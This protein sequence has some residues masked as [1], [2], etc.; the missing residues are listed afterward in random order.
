MRLI[1][2]YNGLV[3]KT[4]TSQEKF[5][6][7]FN[8]G[9]INNF[10][11]VCQD[12]DELF[13][14]CLPASKWLVN[15]DPLKDLKNM[16]SIVETIAPYQFSKV[17]LISTIDVYNGM[18]QGS[19]EDSTIEPTILTYGSN[20]YLFEQMVQTL[21]KTTDLRIFRLPAL[22]SKDIK[23]NVLY[24][25]LNSNMVENI[26]IASKYQW[27]NLEY[28]SRDIAKYS[29]EYPQR[30]TYNLFSEPLETIEIV[31][32]FPQYSLDTFSTKQEVEYDYRTVLSQD[33]YI[34]TK[35]SVLQD[36]RA[37]V[38]EVSSK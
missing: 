5:D 22:F 24:D 34:Y 17:T 23:K 16:I 31:K 26:S 11:E 10:S 15:K 3:G 14:S 35:E 13:L 30:S 37:L 38:D 28:L 18:Q 4:T 19:T 29:N 20:R 25:L 21:V 1:I 2:G 36:I 7:C 33:G 32:L 12:G 27:Y 9:N 8:S 6:Y